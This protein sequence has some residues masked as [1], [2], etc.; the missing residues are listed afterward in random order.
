MDDDSREGRIRD[1]VED[2]GEEVECKENHDAC[3]DSCK[4]GANAAFGLDGSA[5]EGAGS[6][7]SAE[8]GAKD[9]GHSHCNHFLGGVDGVVVDSTE[10]L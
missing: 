3:D 4:R 6:G 2:G 7:V 9:I 10:R 1:V 8:E 5:G